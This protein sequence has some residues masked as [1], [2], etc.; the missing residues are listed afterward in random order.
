MYYIGISKNHNYYIF[1]N[2][3]KPVYQ[4]FKKD[5][6]Y[7]IGGFKTIKQALNNCQSSYKKIFIIDKRKKNQITEIIITNN[8]S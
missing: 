1:R 5:Y 6:L 2:K 8:R 4:E 3:N 7:I